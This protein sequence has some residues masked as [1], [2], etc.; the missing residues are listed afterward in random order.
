MAPKNVRAVFLAALLASGLVVLPQRAQALTVPSLCLFDPGSDAIDARC[1]ETLRSFMLYWTRVHK[2][3]TEAQQRENSLP[4]RE[5]RVFIYGS[6]DTAEQTRGLAFVHERRAR[7]VAEAL[8]AAGIPRQ[9]IT[10]RGHEENLLVPTGPNVSERQNR[11]A[12][13]SLP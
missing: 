10:V 5:A 3:R 8:I 7:A 6:T 2:D 12:R 13:L 11:S 1:E 4:V 9:L